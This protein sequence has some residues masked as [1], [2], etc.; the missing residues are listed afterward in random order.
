M[1][2]STR[3]IV[4]SRGPADGG[5]SAAAR[6]EPSSQGARP[7]GA[8]QVP[9]MR[10]EGTSRRFDQVGG[11]RSREPVHPWQVRF[12]LLGAHR[13]WRN[14]HHCSPRHF[15]ARTVLPAT[16]A[17]LRAVQ[18]EGRSVRYRMAVLGLGGPR[19]IQSHNLHRRN[20]AGRVRRCC[21]AA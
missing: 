12:R 6:T 19:A 3:S 16:T 15:L 4:P 17:K 8:G 7:Q 13:A 18:I 1:A 14:L 9:R 20:C 2:I 21:Y 10:S 5:I 11:G